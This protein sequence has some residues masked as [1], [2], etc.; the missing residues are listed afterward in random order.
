[1]S[2][3][4]IYETVFVLNPDLSEEEVAAGVQSTIELLETRGSEIIRTEPGGKRRLAYP[5][6]K[7]RYGFYSLIH[8][9]GT[10]EA[11]TELE[12]MYRLND[13]V[14]RYLTVRF[15]KEEHLTGLTRMGDDEGR[16]DDRDDRSGLDRR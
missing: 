4:R 1:M 3:K 10:S 6:E 12:R 11:L 7:Q 15:D 14:L 2:E 13:K 9:R 8:F 16:D 5:I